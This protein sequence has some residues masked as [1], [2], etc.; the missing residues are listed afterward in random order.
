MDKYKD[1]E[2]NMAIALLKTC[3]DP[4]IAVN[5]YDLGLIYAVNFLDTETPGAHLLHVVMTLTSPGCGMGPIL[6]QDIEEKCRAI[7]SV[8]E[9]KVELVFDPPWQQHMMSDEAKLHLGLIY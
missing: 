7:P 2:K 3:Y 8:Q 9:V 6:L 4:E 1:D 5:I